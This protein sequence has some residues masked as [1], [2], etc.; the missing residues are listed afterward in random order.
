MKPGFDGNAI[1][2]TAQNNMGTG[3]DWA[4]GF[5]NQLNSQGDNYPYPYQPYDYACCSAL[6]GNPPPP[7]PPTPCTLNPGH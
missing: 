3:A 2:E 6:S 4:P 5:Y 1:L 7:H